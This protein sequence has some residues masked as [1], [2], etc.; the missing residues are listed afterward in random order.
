MKTSPARTPL[1]ERRSPLYRGHLVTLPYAKITGGTV[2][3]ITILMAAML[4]A[5]PARAQPRWPD[6]WIGSWA[7]SQQVPEPQNALG[8][9]DLDDATLRQT[10]HLSIGGAR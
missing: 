9:H 8:V 7:T 4:L 5:A 10:V 6:K 2:R 3:A 1:S